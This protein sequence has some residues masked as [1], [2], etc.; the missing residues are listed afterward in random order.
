MHTSGLHHLA[1]PARDV[2]ESAAFYRD[3][4]GLLEIT[5]HFTPEGGLRSVWL[6]IEARDGNQAPMLMVEK[7]EWPDF[8]PQTVSLALRIAAHDRRAIERE[9][10]ARVEKK[11]RWSLYVRDPS[12]NL[13]AL[14]HHPSDP[15]PE[16]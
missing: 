8:S 1:V 10:G 9:L 12:K 5:R 13:I 7:A 3:M 6:S 14:S 15:P 11:S 4:L 16:E 2:E